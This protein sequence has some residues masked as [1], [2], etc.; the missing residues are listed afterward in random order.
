[1]DFKLEKQRFKKVKNFAFFQK[2][3]EFIVFGQKLEILS[4]FLLQKNGPK[5][6][7]L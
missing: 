5:Q 2:G 7:V 6:S 1:M 3:G 4:F